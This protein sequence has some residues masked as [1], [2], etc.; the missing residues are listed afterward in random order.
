M[1]Q[2]RKRSLMDQPEV[3]AKDMAGMAGDC[4]N[5]NMIMQEHGMDIQFQE[6]K[7]QH[8][9]CAACVHKELFQIPNI[10]RLQE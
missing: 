8:R 5:S 4:M 6:T 7:R 3:G 2:R 9:Y 10:T 1:P